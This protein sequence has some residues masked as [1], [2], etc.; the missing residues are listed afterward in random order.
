MKYTLL[1]LVAL[2]TSLFAHASPEA[3]FTIHIYHAD[4]PRLVNVPDV[5]A[6]IRETPIVSTQVSVPLGSKL[7]R[8]F[9]V[10]SPA[11][12]KIKL[13]CEVAKNGDASASHTGYSVSGTIAYSGSF[14]GVRFASNPAPILADGGHRYESVSAVSVVLGGFWLF[15]KGHAFLC[16]VELNPIKNKTEPNQALEPTSMVGTPPAAQE[17]RQP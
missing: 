1:T 16:I 8:E 14:D 9:E 4:N 3:D 2:L 11:E 10:K 6:W 5:S 13:D 7:K 12:I 15:Q 17:P